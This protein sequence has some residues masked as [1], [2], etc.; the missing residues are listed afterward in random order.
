MTF[1]SNS[2]LHLGLSA[3]LTARRAAIR[4]HLLS[5][6]GSPPFTRVLASRP[7]RQSVDV[8]SMLVPSERTAIY[9]YLSKEARARLPQAGMTLFDQLAFTRKKSTLPAASEWLLRTSYIADK[10]VG[11][12]IQH[13]STR[14]PTPWAAPPRTLTKSQNTEVSA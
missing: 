9:R 4:Q 7:S 12:T 14:A 8:L 3:A 11:P 5:N 2:S 1:R 10:V 6:H 13:S